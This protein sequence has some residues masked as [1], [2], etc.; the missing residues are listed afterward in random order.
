MTE[1]DKK[2]IEALEENAKILFADSDF[3]DVIETIG[4]EYAY[5][6][7]K[8]FSGGYIYIPKLETIQRAQRDKDIFY[9][10]QQGRSYK[11]IAKK[12]GLSTRSVQGIVKKTLENLADRRKT[13]V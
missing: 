8:C 6:L 10:V 13:E 1:Q 5:K 4:A 7:A 9:E 12:Y 3:Y 2:Y 11:N